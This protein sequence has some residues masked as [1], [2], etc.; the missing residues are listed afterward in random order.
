[1]TM[2]AL[3]TASTRLFQHRVGE[4][5]IVEHGAVGIEAD[6][7]QRRPGRRAVEFLQR[8]PHQHQERQQHD[9]DEIENEDRRGEIAPAAE[10]D[11]ARA[12]ALAG[13][14]G[15]AR[16]LARKPR[17]RV[18]A[19]RGEQQQRH[20]IGGGEPDLARILVDRL[21]DRRRVDVDADRQPEQRRHL[22]RFD[23]AHEQDQQRAERRRP[24]ELA[25]VMRRAI[26]S[27]EAPLIAPIPRAMGPWSGTP[28]SSAGTP[29]ANSAARRPRSCP[30]WCRC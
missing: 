13:D 18:D 17:L 11:G 16:A 7:A 12:K 21:V 4:L 20:R 19:E 25:S 27:T 28:P 2:V 22:E 8:R 24:G 1:M 29:S 30:P 14:G 9:H 26:C 10:V 5:R 23:R 6:A 3:A 15:E